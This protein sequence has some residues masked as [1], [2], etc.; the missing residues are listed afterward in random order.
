MKT[1]FMCASQHLSKRVRVCVYVF[2]CVC[3]CVVD[4]N[5]IK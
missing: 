1:V 2:V 5:L 3:A 4:T